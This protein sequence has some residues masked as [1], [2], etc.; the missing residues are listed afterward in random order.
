MAKFMTNLHC[1]RPCPKETNKTTGSERIKS[2]H[3]HRLQ[4][5]LSQP[6][7][8]SIL[9]SNKLWECLH[10]YRELMGQDS[11]ERIKECLRE[12]SLTYTAA[13]ISWLRTE[14]LLLLVLRGERSAL[15]RRDHLSGN[16]KCPLGAQN[17]Q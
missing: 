4:S 13:G 10:P 17:Y 14:S 16:S 8:I 11:W 12:L 7:S 1:M 2:I 5:L 15:L 6:I 3:I 9:L